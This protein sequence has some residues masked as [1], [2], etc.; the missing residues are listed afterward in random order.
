MQ[1]SSLDR[2][3]PRMDGTEIATVTSQDPNAQ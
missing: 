2:L 3:S 1:I